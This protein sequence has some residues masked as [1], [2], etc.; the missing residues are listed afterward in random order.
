MSEMLARVLAGADGNIGLYWA[1]PEFARDLR[2]EFDKRRAPDDELLGEFDEGLLVRGSPRE[3][4]LRLAW[5]RSTWHDLRLLRFDS[6]GQAAKFLD[7]GALPRRY[8]SA[9]L[10]AHRRAE[11]IQEKLRGY[12]KVWRDFRESL[13]AGE[14][15]GGFLMLDE[16]HLAWSGAVT[17][18]LPLDGPRFPED[19]SAPSRAYL[20]LWESFHRF[21]ELP[22]P[23][24]KCFELGASPGGWTTV[25]RSLGAEVWATDR[26]ELTPALMADPRVHFEKGDGFQWNPARLPAMDWVFSDV[27]CY[28]AKLWDWLQPWLAL[29]RPPKM[30]CTLKFQGGTDFDTLM[31]FAAVPRSQLVHL[32]Q[33]KHELTWFFSP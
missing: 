3:A 26:A 32:F 2:E 33:N 6:I 13:P 25:L 24:A 7:D 4:P 15:F 11:L 19:K 31:K 14:S 17:P 8:I 12:P 1:V 9:S 10:A 22:H 23:E 30:L 20:K 27:I 21:G 28:P 18:R 29:E 16:N 5:A